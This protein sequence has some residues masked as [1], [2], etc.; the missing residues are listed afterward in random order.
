MHMHQWRFPALFA[1]NLDQQQETVFFSIFRTL[2]KAESERRAMG[3]NQPDLVWFICTEADEYNAY[4]HLLFAEEFR[5]GDA[6]VLVRIPHVRVQH[7]IVRMLPEE[8]AQ[9]RVED[10]D[11]AVLGALHR[12]FNDHAIV[13]HRVVR[14]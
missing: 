4:M 9:R 7:E 6:I 1:P 3:N 11:G 5:H 10:A 8:A 14:H 12:A 2:A 13:R